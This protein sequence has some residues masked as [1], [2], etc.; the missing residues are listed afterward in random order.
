MYDLNDLNV[1]DLG[2]IVL[3]NA[4]AIN[5]AGQ[6]LTGVNA[7]GILLTPIG[8]APG[9]IDNNC[10]VN[11]NDLLLLIGEWGQTGSVADINLDGNVNVTDLLALL[12]SWG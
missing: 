8:S 11:V 2:G 10:F 7:A 5:N 6:I 3:R 12:A 9:D 1:T 4:F